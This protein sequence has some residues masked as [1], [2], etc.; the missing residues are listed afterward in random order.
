[1]I[2][3]GTPAPKPTARAVWAA[4]EPFTLWAFF[5]RRLASALNV[6]GLDYFG[7]YLVVRA[8]PLG[9]A[10][11]AVALSCFR[12]LPAEP[13]HEHLERAWR[14]LTPGQVD[15]LAHQAI[16]EACEEQFGAHPARASILEVSAVLD[17][18]VDGLDTRGRPLS[19]A[20]Q[21]VS[22]PEEPWPRLWRR[23][24][25]LREY[26]GEG[27]TAALVLSGL[28]L[29]ETEVLMAAWAGA[30]IDVPRLKA[31]RAIGEEAWHEA[32]D[33]LH[34]RGLLDAAGAMTDSGRRFRSDLEDRTDA[35][36]ACPW[37]GADRAEVELVWGFC[38]EVSDS[39]VQAG[40]MA[41]VTPVGAPW[42]PP[43][44]DLSA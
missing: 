44:P 26:R 34:A 9:M 25:T 32:R 12:S 15:R 30:Q 29:V 35:A 24:N 19:A 31:T 8:A 20:N 16:G 7:T 22:L 1:M 13:M 33:R 21:A 40:Q 3:S 6:P 14:M 10:D 4:A 11:P 28:D 5:G 43:P 23:L 27:H 17:G 18:L 2:L 36:A 41:A 39:L 42:P 38:R 37:T